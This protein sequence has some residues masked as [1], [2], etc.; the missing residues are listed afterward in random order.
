MI[1]VTLTMH[2]NLRRFL[3]DGRGSTRL[4][5]PKGAT[6]RR[7]IEAVHAEHDVWLIALNGT[8]APVWALVT[9]DDR[10]DCFEHLEGG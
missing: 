6:L 4:T 3:P 9:A 7:V 5:V 8:V 1:E 2:G 10:I